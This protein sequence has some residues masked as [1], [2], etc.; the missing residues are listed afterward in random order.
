M[1][2][3]LPR[4]AARARSLK[5]HAA[6]VTVRLGLGCAEH[7]AALARAMYVSW[8]LQRAG[9]GELP[10]AQFH[11][12]EQY[13]ETANRRGVDTDAW[14]FDEDGYPFFERILTLHDLQLDATPAHA[15]IKADEELMRFIHGTEPSPLPPH[16]P[17]DKEQAD[18]L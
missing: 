2:L 9:Y 6:L 18:G 3:P 1:L 17:H 4:E 16:P 10:L 7:L 13:M 15:L 14:Y 11:A 5:F 12:A 8:F